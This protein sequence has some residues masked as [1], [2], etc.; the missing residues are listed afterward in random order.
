MQYDIFNGDADGIC[1]L[2]Q[3]RLD[4]PCPDAIL[5]TGVKR[6]IALLSTLQGITQSSLTVLDISLDSNRPFLQTLLLQSNQ[7]LYIDHHFAGVTPGAAALTTHID[8]APDTCTSLIVD[9]L[10]HGRF[11]KWA[12]VGAFGDNLHEAAHKAAQ[13]L[14]LSGT[15]I[16]QLQELG[17][18]LNYN[19]YG[20]NL[21][22]LYFHPADL[23]RAILPYEDPLDFIA[24]SPSL[25]ILRLGF[26]QDM[27]LAL[28]QKAINP[29]NSNRIFHLPD[30]AWARRISGV[31]ANLKA[32]EKKEAAHALIAPN[33][34]GTLRISVRAP[35]T[36]RKNADTLCRSFPTGGG[37]A[38]AAGINS[39]P[40]EML[41][42]FISAFHATFD[43]SEAKHPISL[44]DS[45]QN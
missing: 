4:T 1:A 39:L 12:I 25:S 6:D 28:S 32:Q 45:S 17:E 18:L 37:R 24:S 15:V 27:T 19:G 2:H 29:D 30:T 26:Q 22:D 34:D 23:Y 33:T 44:N 11:R 38:A 20:A 36:D 16:E 31:F 40:P 8:T 21:S 35:L 3:L 13:T 41:N 7:I 10:L 5:I 9:S 43:K 42:E 14:S